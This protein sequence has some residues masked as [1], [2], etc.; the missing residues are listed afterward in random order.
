VLLGEN[1]D[2][3]PTD[4]AASDPIVAELVPSVSHGSGST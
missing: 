4:L 3:L 1:A 2:L